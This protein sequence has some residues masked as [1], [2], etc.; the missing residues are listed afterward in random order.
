[1]I[2]EALRAGHREEEAE[3]AIQPAASGGPVTP[4][5]PS[6]SGQPWARR[7][8]T[9]LT[10]LAWLTIGAAALWAAGHVGRTLLMVAV[11]G[12]IAYALY[13]AVHLLS[14]YL[15]RPLAILLVY[16]VLLAGLGLLVYVTLTTAITQISAFA[17]QVRVWLTPGANGKPSPLL[18][19]VNDLGITNDQ[20]D[21]ARQQLINQAEGIASNLAPLVS[22]VVNAVLDL[23]LTAILSVYLLVDGSRLG[24]WL[25]TRVP[26]SQRGR[27][28]F[29]LETQQRV[30]G[31]YIRGQ[32]IISM[33]LAVL[34]AAGMFVLHVPFAVLLGMLAFV[35]VF[36]P[37]IGTFASGAACVLVAL[38]QGWVTAVIV[39]AYFV[40][41]HLV[42]DDLVAPRVMGRSVGVHP[43]VSIVAVVAGGELFGLWGALLASPLAGVLQAVVAYA[44]IAWRET[45]RDQFP[46]VTVESAAPA[47]R[48]AVLAR[49]GVP[50]AQGQGETAAL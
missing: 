25:R 17:G 19:L 1:V 41:L 11:A 5:G 27:V 15:P 40:V 29:L 42:V 10:V 20:I 4:A 49:A 48:G 38:T 44:W 26:I 36:V 6:P 7:R 22:S 31:G 30:V 37:V 13:P 45:H 21:A 50:P 18:S 33:L 14:R 34:V 24:R 28:D 23:V 47:D 32:L 35:L 3:M 8:D 43:A 9:A 46:D 2:A 12:L 39:L 16:C